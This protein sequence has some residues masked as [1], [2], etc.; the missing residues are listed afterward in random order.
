MRKLTQSQLR[1]CKTQSSKI[2]RKRAEKWEKKRAQVLKSSS[3]RSVK[4]RASLTELDGKELDMIRD[5]SDNDR[6]CVETK[7]TNMN[8]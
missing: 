6:D 1:L 5:Q 2:A 3:S 8:E 4:M 7:K